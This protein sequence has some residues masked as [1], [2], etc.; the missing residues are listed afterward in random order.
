MKLKKTLR[1]ILT[2]FFDKLILRNHK[3][4]EK[5]LI[6]RLD[7]IGDYILFRNFIK[8]IK[9]QYPKYELTF[10]GNVLVKDLAESYDN[11]IIDHFIWVNNKININKN[12]FY[13]YRLFK[14]INRERF[15]ICICPAFTKAVGET[16]QLAK[17]TRSPLRISFEPSK[18]YHTI[19]RLKE[20]AKIYNKIIMGSPDIKFE[21]ERNKEFVQKTF[22]IN[23]DIHKPYFE[24]IIKPVTPIIEG[25]YCTIIPGASSKIRRW[26]LNKFINIA[27][28]IYENYKIRTLFLG[29][30]DELSY[31]KD[32]N[33]LT[34]NKNIINLIG[35]TNLLD[36]VY[37]IANSKLTLTNESSAYHIAAS[38]GSPLICLS[39]GNH[40]GRFSPYP[41]VLKNCFT[42]YPNHLL[43]LS[44]DELSIKYSEFSLENINLINETEV[45][46]K[47]NLVL[48]ETK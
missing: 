38:C 42:L 25:D 16:D 18:F 27:N 15:E 12:F 40:F 3:G 4:S 17:S 34:E 20:A 19:E 37:Y 36:Y 13:R 24:K 22:N 44:P 28:Y 23:T 6:I 43:A 35:K 31:L 33:N 9:L 14:Q 39:N 48:R 32:L 5:I 29:S 45:I 47:I 11:K 41:S 30:K 8:Y 7:L 21:F 2:S 10:C 1:L 46:N 26:E